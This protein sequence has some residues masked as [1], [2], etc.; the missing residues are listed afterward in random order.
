MYFFHTQPHLLQPTSGVYWLAFHYQAT[1][2]GFV[3]VTLKGRGVIFVSQCLL[4]TVT[5]LVRLKKGQKMRTPADQPV[6]RKGKLLPHV[7][8]PPSG[9]PPTPPAHAPA[10]SAAAA[11]PSAAA[12][13]APSAGDERGTEDLTDSD[14]RTLLL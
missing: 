1:A 5:E 3:W 9:L 12:G 6:V 14:G 10:P 8:L 7:K 2:D 4:S 11:A 13:A